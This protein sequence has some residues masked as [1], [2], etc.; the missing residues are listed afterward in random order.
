MDAV[1]MHHNEAIFP[2]SQAFSPE[3]WLE[4]D[5]SGAK[6]INRKLQ[7]YNIA[8]SRGTRQCVGMNLAYAELFLMLSTLFRRYEMKLYETGV[9]S[10]KLYGDF[11]LPKPKPGTEGVQVLV[12]GLSV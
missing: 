6:I 12:K 9:D 11:F 10:V 2:N 1:H 3:R 7:R 8:F 4:S 5:A